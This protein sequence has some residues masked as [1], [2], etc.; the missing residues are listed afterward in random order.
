MNN[1]R[2]LGKA[3]FGATDC[4]VAGAVIVGATVAASPLLAVL[5][6]SDAD[7][8]QYQCWMLTLVGVWAL[9]SWRRLNRS[10]LHP[11]ILLF[12]SAFAF[13]GAPAVLQL[14]GLGNYE[15]L[16]QGFRSE[17][18]IDTLALVIMCMASLHLG[19]L[20]GS[21]RNKRSLSS[22]TGQDY[23]VPTARRLAAGLLVIGG[24]AMVITLARNIS[25]V[26]SQGYFALYQAEAASGL[27]GSGRV[28]GAL[29][30]PAALYVLALS[31]R[32]RAWAG[33]ALGLIFAYCLVTLYLGG[34]S[35]SAMVL[36]S[37]AWLVDRCIR[38]VPRVALIAGLI[39]LLAIFSVVRAV[40]SL[41]GEQRTSLSRL[42][43]EMKAIDQPVVRSVE[44]IGGTMRIVSYVLELV[45]VQRPFDWGRSY[46][47][48][49]SAVIPN[50]FWDLH[51]AVSGGTPAQWLIQVVDPATARAGGG[52]GFSFIA[53]AYL[54]FGWLGAPA[55]MVGLGL[56]FG[57]LC[58]WGDASPD[59]LKL[60][61]LAGLTAMSL[62]IVRNDSTAA[63][64]ILAWY[65]FAPYIILRY[66][67]RVK[68]P[69]RVA[70]SPF[71]FPAQ[72]AAAVLE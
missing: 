5:K 22:P 53:E 50:L 61:M 36:M 41:P 4:V 33:M 44:E 52:I 6:L 68:A 28:I 66:V 39:G 24:V 21:Q 49:F 32:K 58:A 14:T 63:F 65:S 37:T 70:H 16:E 64:R 8:I 35:P 59:P 30:I 29:F 3:A 43:E 57:R 34:R 15:L 71:S 17:T 26:Y 45:P 31:R 20:I 47:R 51:P 42:A 67:A 12:G 2:I 18:I 69:R 54:N 10:L 62:T 23:S 48:S 25:L 1:R 9:W 40:R 7:S 55:V 72:R 60:A 13:H 11:Y 27:G 38:R 56:L 19:A 46:L